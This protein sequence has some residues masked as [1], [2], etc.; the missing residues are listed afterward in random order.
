[1]GV[2]MAKVDVAFLIVIGL[3]MKANI[4]V[5]FGMKYRVFG[6]TSHKVEAL[7]QSSSQNP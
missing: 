7:S 3:E 1:M 6:Y 4:Y 2:N 5:G